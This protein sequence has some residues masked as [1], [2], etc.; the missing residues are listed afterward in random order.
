MSKPSSSPLE[1]PPVFIVEVNHV[2]DDERARGL[3]WTV[4]GESGSGE[5]EQV[6]EETEGGKTDSDCSDNFVYGE[7]VAGEGITEKEKCGLEHER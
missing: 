2:A 3:E 1:V 7:E 5:N 4:V 6:E